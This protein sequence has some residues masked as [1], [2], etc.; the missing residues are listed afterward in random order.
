MKKIWKFLKHH[1]QEDFHLG[2]YLS[3]ATFLP[4]ILLLNYWFDFEDTYLENMDGWGKFFAYVL[5]YSFPYL[6]AVWL[7]AIF[8]QRTD[9]FTDRSFWIKSS[10]GLLILSLDS[11]V[12]F[13]SPFIDHYL[14]YPI[15]FWAYKVMVN[16]ISFLTVMLPL[17]L[18][19]LYYDRQLGTFYGLNQKRFD[20]RPYFIM[21]AIMLP[22]IILASYN[23]AFMRQY[24]MYKTTAAHEYLG[25]AEW[26][27]VAAYEIAYGLDFVTVELL[28]RGF[29]V[30]GMMSILGRSAVVSMAVVYCTLH[31]G[32]PAGEAVSSIFGGYILGVVAYETKS[33]WGGVIVHMGIAWMMELVAFI[34]KLFQN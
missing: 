16:G 7:W 26:I 1:V 29:F 28:F 23:P 3:V 22:L 13:L 10:A 20:A 19:Y 5:F 11:S 17:F 34:Q 33:I 2:H 21:L 15:Q 30:I 8:R 32:K 25:I 6:F 12:P 24:P 14:P 18:F 4:V 31:F 9:I 27:T